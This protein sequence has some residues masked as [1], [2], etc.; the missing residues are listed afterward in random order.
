MSYMLTVAT[1]LIR[2]I[3]LC[4]ADHEAATA[5]DPDGPDALFDNERLRAQLM[6]GGAEV[7]GVNVR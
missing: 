7:F 3:D 2:G 1:A 4:R 6:D 5:A